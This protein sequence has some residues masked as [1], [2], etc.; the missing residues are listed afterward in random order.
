MLFIAWRC[1]IVAIRHTTHRYTYAKHRHTR[2]PNIDT[3]RPNI[4][5]HVMC[6]P[7]VKWC[8]TRRQMSGNRSGTAKD[9]SSYKVSQHVR[10]VNAPCVG[11]VCCDGAWQFC[12]C[13]SKLLTTEPLLKN[14]NYWGKKNTHT[15]HFNFKQWDCDCQIFCKWYTTKLIEFYCLFFFIVSGEARKHG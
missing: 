11:R 6:G 12:C 9:M 4:A 1:L 10:R 7:A 14:T 15:L 5:G 8:K 2:R 3:H 13:L